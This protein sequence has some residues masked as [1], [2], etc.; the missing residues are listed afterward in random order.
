M[1]PDNEVDVQQHRR[2]SKRSID[3][4]MLRTSLLDSSSNGYFYRTDASLIEQWQLWDDDENHHNTRPRP[5][6]SPFGL[7]EGLYHDDTAHEI[8]RYLR[9]MDEDE[10]Q[11]CSCHSSSSQKSTSSS[12]IESSQKRHSHFN[13]IDQFHSSLL[14]QQT[15]SFE[16]VV[17]R[18]RHC[19]HTKPPIIIEK[20]LPTSKPKSRLDRQT[21]IKSKPIPYRINEHGEKITDEGNRIVFMD[22]VQM[23]STEQTEPSSKPSIPHERRVRS[24]RSIP[25]IDL[26][27]L[28]RLYDDKSHRISTPNQFDIIEQY[29]EDKQGRKYPSNNVTLQSLVN[30]TESIHLDDKQRRTSLQSSANSKSQHHHR[31]QSTLTKGTPIHYVERPTI[32]SATHSRQQTPILTNAKLQENISNIYGTARSSRSNSSKSSKQNPSAFRYVQTNINRDLIKE[33]RNIY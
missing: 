1:S 15:S 28:E 7:H 21:S 9:R 19:K 13:N 29:F 3:E 5:P 11:S 24:R 17:S 12:S 26:E 23:N 27:S 30:Q 2:K 4:E 25:V 31:S 8:H 22:V 33:Y 6:P 18:H 10:K 16:P 32:L 14:N 20:I